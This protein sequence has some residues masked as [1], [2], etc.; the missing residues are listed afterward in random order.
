[1]KNWLKVP[2]RFKVTTEFDADSSTSVKGVDYIDVP[3]LGQRQHKLNFYSYKETTT[4]IKVTF[5]NEETKEYLYPIPRIFCLR[6]A[7]IIC[8][9]L[10][11][12]L[13]FSAPLKWKLLF[14]VQQPTRFLSKIHSTCPSPSL[15]PAIVTKFP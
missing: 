14:V 9:S 4:N 15:S 8:R 7:F 10:P 3:A 13:K 6:I 2:Q 11:H 1:M 12:R 5:T